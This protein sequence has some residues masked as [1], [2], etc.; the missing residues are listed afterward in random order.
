MTVARPPAMDC[1]HISQAMRPR[2][3]H[4]PI[5][6]G[7]SVTVTQTGAT[8]APSAHTCPSAHAELHRPQWSVLVLASTQIG[9]VAPAGVHT[10]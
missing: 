1:A 8:H 9:Q 3:S 7:G 4:W 2:P 10:V 5:G 6:G